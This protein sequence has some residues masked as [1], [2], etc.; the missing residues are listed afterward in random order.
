MRLVNILIRVYA[1]N[2]KNELR[3]GMP[4]TVMIP[5]DQP[6]EAV[7]GNANLCKEDPDAGP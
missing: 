2:P 5:L 1:C 4:V 3:L 6:Q 7:A